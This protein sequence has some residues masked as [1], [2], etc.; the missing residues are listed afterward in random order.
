MINDIRVGPDFE[1]I[2][3][4]FFFLLLLLKGNVMVTDEFPV[5]SI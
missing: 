4:G 2:M 3:A 1:N 5:N